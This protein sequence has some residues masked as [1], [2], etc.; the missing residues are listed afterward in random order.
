MTRHSL[1][2]IGIIALVLLGFARTSAAETCPVLEGFAPLEALPV[3]DGACLYGAEDAGFT[4]FELPVGPMKGRTV[5]EVKPI[6]GQL[7]RRLYVAPEGASAA[8][9]FLNYRTALLGAGFSPL[10][11]C[12]ARTCGSNNALLGKLI[13]YPPQRK[14]G[15]LGKASEF[16]L[17]I[18]GDEHYMAAVS[19]DGTRHVALYVAQNQKTPISENASERAAV[20]LDLVTAAALESRMIDAAAMAKG[21]SDEGHIALDNVYFDFGTANLSPEAAPAI[22]EMAKLLTANPALK[23]Y[24]VGHTD[25]IGDADTNLSLSQKRAQAVMAALVSSGI[26]AERVAAAGMGM[27]APRASNQTEAGRALNRRVELVERPN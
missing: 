6:E 8:D 1:K 10:F 7:Q 15:N 11:E 13:I 16:A 20:H 21:I 25:W 5:S 3:Y 4:R 23:V 18:D 17:Y 26:A 22:A 27:L 9:V 2:F 12:S 19:A 24:I 14:L